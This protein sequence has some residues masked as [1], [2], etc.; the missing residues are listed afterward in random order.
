MN[1]LGFQ[2]RG[3][4]VKVIRASSLVVVA[5]LWASFVVALF[6]TVKGL[7]DHRRM[8]AAHRHPSSVYVQCHSPVIR[9]SGKLITYYHSCNKR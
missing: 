1:L 6:G 7:I 2:G 5:G 9:S 4:R 8:Y 3:V